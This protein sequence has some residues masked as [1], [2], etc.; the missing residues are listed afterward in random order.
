MEVLDK[1]PFELDIAGLQEHLHIEA[2]SEDSREFGALADEVRQV[3]RPKA[4][5]TE[6]YIEEKGDDSV[7]VGGVTFT[8]AVMRAKLDNVERVF[9]FVATCGR[10]VDAV[11][12][13][14]GDFVKRYWL[15]IIKATLLRFSIGH[16]EAYLDRRYALG[17]TAS[18]SPGSG[19]ATVWPIEQQRPLFSL[20]GGVEDLIGVKLTDSYLMVPIKSVSGIRF[21]TETDFRTCQLCHRENCPSRRAPF[22][23]AL[24]DSM[25]GGQ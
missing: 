16:L 8:S 9:P 24:W 17:K 6:C 23:A 20:L 1:I 19:D 5:Y 2:D 22:D 11:A 15:D 12:V 21:P 4:L 18:M 3:A 14:P 25:Q 7:V 10:E 13:P